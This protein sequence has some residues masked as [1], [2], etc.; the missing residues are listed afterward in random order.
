V[1]Y[2][3]AANGGAFSGFLPPINAARTRSVFK[4]TSTVPVKFRLTCNGAPPSNAV[5]YLTV[6]K[7][8]SNPDGTIRTI[9]EAIATNAATTGNQFRY[10]DGGYHFNL[11]T[12]SG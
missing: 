3:D 7:I 4:L 2:G 10:A 8:D 11:S 12:K 1:V 5:A 6:Q 9:N